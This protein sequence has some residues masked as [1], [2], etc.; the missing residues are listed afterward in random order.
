[1]CFFLS[2]MSYFY[3]QMW[4]CASF[5]TTF[6]QMGKDPLDTRLEMVSPAVVFWDAH[7]RPSI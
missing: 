7:S 4:F 6:A 3:Y 2:D 5:S 1:M